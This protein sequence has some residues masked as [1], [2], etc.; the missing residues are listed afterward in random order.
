MN[1]RRLAGH[2]KQVPQPAT[3][4]IF[5]SLVDCVGTDG[6]KGAGEVKLRLADATSASLMTLLP[7][8]WN[9]CRALLPRGSQRYEPP[10]IPCTAEEWHRSPIDN[11]VRSYCKSSR[12]LEDLPWNVQFHTAVQCL[13]GPSNAVK[14]LPKHHERQDP[15]RSSGILKGITCKSPSPRNLSLLPSVLHAACSFKTIECSY[16]R[17]NVHLQWSVPPGLLIQVDCL[18]TCSPGWSGFRPS[19]P[20]LGTPWTCLSPQGALANI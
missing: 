10:A 8:G 14:A 6:L 11:A 15:G 7:S 19:P 5:M 18:L 1:C 17:A 16:W 3:Q 13:A 20:P 4:L 9:N 12:S 2:V